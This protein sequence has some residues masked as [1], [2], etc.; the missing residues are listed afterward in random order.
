[1]WRGVTPCIAAARSHLAANERNPVLPVVRH[2]RLQLAGRRSVNAKDSR[3]IKLLLHGE[4]SHVRDLL[5]WRARRLPSDDNRQRLHA[6]GNPASND[7]HC[8]QCDGAMR[9][10][11]G[12]S[13]RD[14]GRG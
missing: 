7:V 14:K 8:A 2:H 3:K 12:V 5:L 1:M 11:A 9:A 13:S 4:L 6:A 10:R